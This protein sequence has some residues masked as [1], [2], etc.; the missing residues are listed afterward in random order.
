[1]LP[2]A[3]CEVKLLKLLDMPQLSACLECRHVRSGIRPLRTWALRLQD[4]AL[5]NSESGAVVA[6]RG[7]PR[8]CGIGHEAKTSSVS[9]KKALQHMGQPVTDRHRGLFGAGA[10][11]AAGSTPLA[12]KQADA[13]TAG[14]AQ[15]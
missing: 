12:M 15:N 6:L 9:G 2:I 10:S 14:T 1:M 3:A 5:P 11:C 4:S 8:K 13:W 7:S